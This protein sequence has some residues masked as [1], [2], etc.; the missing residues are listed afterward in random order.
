MIKHTVRQVR[1]DRHTNEIPI[2]VTLISK[3]IAEEILEAAQQ[4]GLCGKRK[5]RKGDEEAGRVGFV[6]KSLTEKE[7]KE[8][9]DREKFN[10][11]PIGKNHSEL[12]K[13]EENFRTDEDEWAKMIIEDQD[14]DSESAVDEDNTMGFGLQEKK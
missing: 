4:F 6:R 10:N 2:T 3:E 11:S 8:I 12:R 5:W 9:K 14:E 1:N 13:R 7:R